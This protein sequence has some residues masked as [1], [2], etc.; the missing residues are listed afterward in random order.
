M[1][2]PMLTNSYL[3]IISPRNKKA[4]EAAKMGEVFWMK[5]SLDKEINLT[6][7]LNRKK[8]RVPV[9]DLIITNFH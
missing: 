8:V 9:M 2:T 1:H 6:A 7:A 5:A 4:M 3:D